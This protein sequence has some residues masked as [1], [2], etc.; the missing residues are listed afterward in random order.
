MGTAHCRSNREN[1]APSV[2]RFGTKTLDV[3]DKTNDYKILNIVSHPEYNF[4]S[5][6]NDIALFE[7]EM[8]IR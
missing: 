4:K 7:L 5:K 8:K 3:D 2:A 6:Y 1:I